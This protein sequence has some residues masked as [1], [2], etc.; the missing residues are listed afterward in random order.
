MGGKSPFAIP[1]T[2]PF[3]REAAVAAHI[4][5]VKAFENAGIRR[6]LKGPPEGITKLT[7]V[8]YLMTA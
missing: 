7:P 1:F 6:K 2:N 4:V 8:G 5:C 3:S